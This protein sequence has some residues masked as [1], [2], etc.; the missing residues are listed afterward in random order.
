MPLLHF[1]ANKDFTAENIIFLMRVREW[2]Q[3][4][5]SAPRDPS[6]GDVTSHARNLLF[7]LAVEIYMVCVLDTISEFPINIDHSVRSQL[8]LLF[9]PAVPEA[10]KRVSSDTDGSNPFDI[11]MN[12]TSNTHID[13]EVKRIALTREESDDSLK[14]STTVAV[15]SVPPTFAP[16]TTLGSNTF[17]S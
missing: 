8:D 14:K 13:E 15:Y 3:A 4:W 17:P 1:A 7:R 2:R 9:E 11:E 16:C 12:Y 10:K 5:V 6:T